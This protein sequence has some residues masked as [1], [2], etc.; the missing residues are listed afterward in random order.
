MAEKK[1]YLVDGFYLVTVRI[2]VEAESEEEAEAL[3]GNVKR[4][5]NQ[6]ATIIGE[7]PD[8]DTLEIHE[9]TAI[10]ED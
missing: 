6:G 4:S 5:C 1:T 2:Q 8:Y 3:A 10:E 9:D 7:Y